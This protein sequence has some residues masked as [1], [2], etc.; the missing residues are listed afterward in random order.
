MIKY[1]WRWICDICGRGAEDE[2]EYDHREGYTVA[3]AHITPKFSWKQLD[4]QLICDRHK[5]TIEDA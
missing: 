1:R 3:V 2:Q 5:V 4:D